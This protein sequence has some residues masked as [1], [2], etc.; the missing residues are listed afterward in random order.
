MRSIPGTEDCSEKLLRGEEQLP[1]DIL[2]SG[3]VRSSYPEILRPAKN[4]HAERHEPNDS[5]NSSNKNTKIK[6]NE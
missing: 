5:G 3:V 2:G 4:G 1:V 6:S